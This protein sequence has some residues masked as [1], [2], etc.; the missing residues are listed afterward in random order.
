MSNYTQQKFRLGTVLAHW[1]D[2]LLALP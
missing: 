2:D 1:G